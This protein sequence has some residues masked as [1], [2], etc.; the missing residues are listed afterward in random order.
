MSAD[1]SFRA[2]LVDDAERTA[3]EGARL[4]QRHG[5]DATAETSEGGPTWLRIVKAAEQHGSDLV[6]LGSHGRS[7]IAYAVLGSV[8]TAVAHHSPCP[9]LIA[10]GEVVHPSLA[11]NGAQAHT[12][13]RVETPKETE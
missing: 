1:E 7:G 11:V 13:P 4:A 10:Q 6:V 5:F 12:S 3:A 9:V 2:S 8:A